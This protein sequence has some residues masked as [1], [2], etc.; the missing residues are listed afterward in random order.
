MMQTEGRAVW[1]PL[2]FLLC[3]VAAS[4][5]TPLRQAEAADDIARTLAGSGDSGIEAVDGGVGDDSGET[6]VVRGG[7]GHAI[8]DAIPPAPPYLIAPPPSPI[9]RGEHR[10]DGRDAPPPMGSARRHAW[11]Q[12]LLF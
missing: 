4:S 7:P 1:R 5:G 9:G 2:M 12:R 11:L 10:T 8:A 6:V 3:L